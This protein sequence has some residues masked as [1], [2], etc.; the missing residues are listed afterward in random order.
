LAVFAENLK[1]FLGENA[2]NLKIFLAVFAE[3]LTIFAT[4]KG[5]ILDGFALF[6]FFWGCLRKGGRWS[7]A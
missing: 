2:R 5:E 7:I 6:G 1:I 4:K 3:N